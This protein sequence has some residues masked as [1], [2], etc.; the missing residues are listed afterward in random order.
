MGA[1][2]VHVPG[3]H[4]D[5]LVARVAALERALAALANKTLSSASIGAGGLTLNAGGTITANG[6]ANTKIVIDPNGPE[7]DF[8]PDATGQRIQQLVIDGGTDPFGNV[9]PL[10]FLQYQNAAQATSGGGLALS[11]TGVVI[12]NKTATLDSFIY[13]DSN[14]NVQAKG[15]W[16]QNQGWSGRPAIYASQDTWGVG[17]AAI[18]ESYSVTMATAPLVLGMDLVSGGAGAAAMYTTA[19]STTGWNATVTGTGSHFTRTWAFRTQ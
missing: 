18:A 2:P 19:E 7:I 12:S 16:A 10:L 13:I 8:Y 9:I 14:G 4:N 15:G 6:T 5:P 17:T 1:I 3:S 11:A